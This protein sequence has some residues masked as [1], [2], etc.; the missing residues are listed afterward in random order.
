MALESQAFIMNIRK[1]RVCYV[2]E[3]MYLEKT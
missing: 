3:K 1:L 2:D